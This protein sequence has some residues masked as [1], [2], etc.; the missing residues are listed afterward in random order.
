[1][2][3]R[4]L[5][6]T[7]F[8]S[9][10][11]P[12]GVGTVIPATILFSVLSLLMRLFRVKKQTAFASTERF[13]RQEGVLFSYV[14]PKCQNTTYNVGETREVAGLVSKILNLQVRR[15]K[16]VTCTRCGF[17]EY[18]ERRQSPISNVVDLFVR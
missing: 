8:R 3:T 17:T 11:V 6:S 1:M 18:F 14:C 10:L 2:S 9:D 5:V 4:A 13:P 15:F 16:T 7:H 12:R